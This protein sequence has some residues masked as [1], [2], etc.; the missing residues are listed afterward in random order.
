MRSAPAL[1]AAILAA[2]AAAPAYAQLPGLP[3]GLDLKGLVPEKIAEPAAPPA[4]V[5][6]GAVDD[7]AT[8]L[9]F[10]PDG[11]ALAVG[12]FEEVVTFA[13]AT[14]QPGRALRTRRGFA[15]ALHWPDADELVVGEYGRVSTWDPTTGKRRKDADPVKV[16]G[17]CLA[18]ALGPGLLA[19]DEAG[20]VRR[21]I[22]AIPPEVLFPKE[23]PPGPPVPVRGLAVDP[24]GAGVVLA[25]GDPE[26]ETAAGPVFLLRL[27][28]GEPVG[29]PVPLPEHARAAECCAFSAG[30]GWVATG[31]AD[32]MV[33]LTRLPRVNDDGGGEP[34]PVGRYAGQARPV[35]AI[36][37]LPSPDSAPVFVTAGGG[38]AKGGNAVRV[39]RYEP[40]DLKAEG[41]KAEGGGDDDEP[42]GKV[43]DLAVV[44]DFAAP[45][46]SLAL[47]PDG[48]A[49]AVGDDAGTVRVLRV[50]DL[51]GEFAPPTVREPLT[52]P[53]P[54]RKDT[55]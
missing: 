52:A 34:E 55:E 25:T 23:P 49:L 42:A 19:A 48:T 47:S 6:V 7:R 18:L 21:I 43:R 50:A 40:A 17:Y 15:E 20:T 28:N 24:N 45:V 10:S 27:E 26:R 5:W 29:E 44:D 53:K 4:P 46:R 3:D 30:G 13:A 54:D 9:A 12:T 11:A 1:A 38:R 33:R 51:L 31:G 22:G 37:S 32:E 36:L 39:W 8:A 14:G 35:N 41:G 16:R 2:F